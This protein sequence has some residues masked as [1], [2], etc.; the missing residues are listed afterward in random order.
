[1]ELNLCQN[2]IFQ[3]SMQPLIQYNR[4]SPLSM[5]LFDASCN[6]ECNVPVLCNILFNQ[7]SMFNVGFN[8]SCNALFNVPFNVG[9][10]VPFNVEFNVPF[11]VGFNVPF[12]VGFNVPFNVGFNVPGFNVPFNVGFNVPF[13]VGFN[14]PFNV[15]FKCYVPCIILFNFG[16]NKCSMQCFIQCQ[17]QS[18]LAEFAMFDLSIMLECGCQYIIQVP[19]HTLGITHHT[20]EV[21]LY[22]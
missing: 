22:A 16:F 11:N 20:L 21:S 19:C 8:V 2:S 6:V 4:F 14:V 7:C 17:I 12:N 5:A 1:M 18:G 10:N 9:F 3:S 15:E 13:N